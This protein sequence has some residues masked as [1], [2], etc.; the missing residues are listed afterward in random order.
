MAA[1]A[2]A[3]VTRAKLTKTA[4]IKGATAAIERLNRIP[5]NLD[6]L[7]RPNAVSCKRLARL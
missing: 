7:R 3:I 5:T 1:G 2:A 4:K 6:P